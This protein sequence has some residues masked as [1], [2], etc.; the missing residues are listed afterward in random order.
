M[1]FP[2]RSGEQMRQNRQGH[3]LKGYG[4]PMEKLQIVSVICLPQRRNFLR[5]KFIVIGLKNTGFQF[6]LRKVCKIELHHLVGRLGI[7]HLLQ[8]LKGLIQ[9]RNPLRHKK[10]SL[11]REPF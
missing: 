8:F 10:P 11:L 4:C 2:G 5:V 7:S 9:S 6:F 1:I 3:V